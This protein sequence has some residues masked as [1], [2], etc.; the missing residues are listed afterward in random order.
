[1]DGP[2]AAKFE[3]KL[4]VF[5]ALSEQLEK[6][7]DDTSQITANITAFVK[8]VYIFVW[9]EKHEHAFTDWFIEKNL[10]SYFLVLL[11]Q[12]ARPPVPRDGLVNVIK[13]YSFFILNVKRI[14]TVNYV[15]SHANFNSFLTFPFDF[16]DEEVVFYFTNFIKSLTQKFEKFPFQIFYNKVR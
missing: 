5:M 8:L 16:D 12:A 13:C 14:E 4:L 11:G 10:F 9:G 3:E 6:T 7:A 1:M 2:N 15:F